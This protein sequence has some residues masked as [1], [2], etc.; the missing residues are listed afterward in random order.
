MVL[1]IIMSVC[2]WNHEQSR[3]GLTILKFKT[4]ENGARSDLS[5][6]A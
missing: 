3:N 4:N 2:N 5:F 6:G 1:H